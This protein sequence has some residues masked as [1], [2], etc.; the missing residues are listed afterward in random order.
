MASFRCYDN[1]DV[2][3]TPIITNVHLYL[4]QLWRQ[5]F[6]IFVYGDVVYTQT[7]EVL[8]VKSSIEPSKRAIPAGG[9][10]GQKHLQ[11][12]FQRSS[13]TR[14]RFRGTSRRGAWEQGWN[15]F[16]RKT[17]VTHLLMM[18]NS[19]VYTLQM[20]ERGNNLWLRN[21]VE[22]PSD[23]NLVSSLL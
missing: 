23:E 18:T 13:P 19:I 5:L 16:L 20:L 10:L 1:S 17:K 4:I 7:W 21:T 2:I 22:A 11:T 9:P 12:S 14:R 3:A 15:I 8:T 6:Q